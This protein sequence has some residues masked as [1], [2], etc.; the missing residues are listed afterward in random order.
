MSLP[1]TVTTRPASSEPADLD[2]RCAIT[3][4]GGSEVALVGLIGG[5]ADTGVNPAVEPNTN[6]REASGAVERVADRIRGSPADGAVPV[7]LC[8]R[9]PKHVLEHRG[10]YSLRARPVGDHVHSDV[11]G[12]VISACWSGLGHAQRTHL[13]S[14]DDY[15]RTVIRDGCFD[16]APNSGNVEVDSRG[17]NRRAR[18]KP[19]E[20]DR[21]VKH[22]INLVRSCRARSSRVPRDSAGFDRNEPVDL[23]HSE[24]ELEERLYRIRMLEE[25]RE[26]VIGDTARDQIRRGSLVQRPVN[27]PR[28]RHP[29][30]VACVTQPSGTW[31]LRLRERHDDE[32][33]EASSVRRRVPDSTVDRCADGLDRFGRLGQYMTRAQ[34]RV[35]SMP[36]RQE[37]SHRLNVRAADSPHVH[38]CIVARRGGKPGVPEWVWRRS[39]PMTMCSAQRGAAVEGGR[40]LRVSRIS[41]DLMR[42]CGRAG[43][44]GA[45]AGVSMTRDRRFK[46]VVRARAERDGS[47]YSAARASMGDDLLDGLPGEDTLRWLLG[48]HRNGTTAEELLQHFT[49]P[50]GAAALETSLRWWNDSPDL[51]GWRRGGARVT[52]VEPADD[53][54]VAI[55]ADVGEERWELQVRLEPTAPFRVMG[56]RPQIT[57]IHGRAWAELQDVVGRHRAVQSE[58]DAAHGDRVARLLD[59]WVTT[60]AVPGVAVA[61]LHEGE[62]VHVEVRGIAALSQEVPVTETTLFGTGSVT[63]VVVALA[64]LELQD[65][66]VV[67]IEA[68]LASYL[69]SIRVESPDGWKAPTIRDLLTHRGGFPRVLSRREWAVPDP[70][71]VWDATGGTV[72]PVA[73]PTEFH[74]SNL[75]YAL[76]GALICDVTGN[77]LHAALRELVFQPVGLDSSLISPTA[78]PPPGPGG[79]SG[80]LSA[81]GVVAVYSPVVTPYLGAGGLVTNLSDLQRLANWLL[82]KPRHRLNQMVERTVLNWAKEDREARQGLGLATWRHDSRYVVFHNG[83]FNGFSA[84]VSMSPEHSAAVVLLANTIGFDK[85]ANL[86]LQLFDAAGFA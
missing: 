13:T 22:R 31:S 54:R 77:D 81:H 18:M 49:N 42:P 64:L 74:Y 52:R 10:A 14:E 78:A 12:V 23:V 51:D 79:P 68:P 82:A 24:L 5:R 57:P 41:S 61:I 2:Q 9:P 3:P 36:L 8:A 71:D 58:L 21:E 56:Y 53:E 59:S 46:Q 39:T 29:R 43:T 19:L 17:E 69:T 4:A 11:D 73:P 40:T 60:H 80:H 62:A 16:T 65:R 20:F 44:S 6:W 84:L 35:I 1:Q 45:A 26:R 72:R 25:K 70:R 34:R 55:W 33:L 75:G 63:K 7:S 37:R 83:S 48:I 86:D 50:G 85:L 32:A 15:D 30:R 28:F 27:L 38:V 47:S 67:D 66:G 76:L